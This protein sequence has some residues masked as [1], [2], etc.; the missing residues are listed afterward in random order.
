MPSL[1]ERREDIPLLVRHILSVLFE[2]TGIFKSITN[3]SMDILRAYD[4]PGNVRELRNT[5]ERIV[6]THEAGTIT[7][8]SLPDHLRTSAECPPLQAVYGDL[9]S[10]SRQAERVAIKKALET[11]AGNITEAA[12]I[13]KISRPRL[14][15]KKQLYEL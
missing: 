14:Y 8:D 4:W 13:L 5:L 10:V 2:E 9:N 1:R 6:I 15:R 3:E 12:K 7:A 11:A